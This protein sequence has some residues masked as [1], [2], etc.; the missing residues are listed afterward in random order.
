MSMAEGQPMRP[1]RAPSFSSKEKPAIAA[2]P[3]P[4][5]TTALPPPPDSSTSPAAQHEDLQPAPVNPSSKSM[6][7]SEDLS[8]SESMATP[9]NT[10]KPTSDNTNQS[11]PSKQRSPPPPRP[12]PAKQQSTEVA[13]QSACDGDSTSVTARPKAQSTSGKKPPPPRPA[14]AAPEPTQASAIHQHP[15][16]PAKPAP[17][18]PSPAQTSTNANPA[19]ADAPE[20]TEPSHGHAP[21]PAKAAPKLKD[22]PS[23]EH[24]APTDATRSTDE[25]PPADA[26][27]TP[28]SSGHAP[29]PARPPHPQ[30]SGSIK[31][32]RPPPARPAHPAPTPK[33]IH[34]QPQSKDKASVRTSS[35]KT[36]AKAPL[37]PSPAAAPPKPAAPARPAAPAQPPEL[38]PRPGPGHVLY[39]YMVTGPRVIEDLPGNRIYEGWP[40]GWQAEA[41]LV[42]DPK[43]E[44][45]AEEVMAQAFEDAYGADVALNNTEPDEEGEINSSANAQAELLRKGLPEDGADLPVDESGPTPDVV[46]IASKGDTGSSSLGSTEVEPFLHPHSIEAGPP[47]V[48]AL[49]DFVAEGPDDLAFFAGQELTVLEDID[50]EWYRGSL[51]PFQGIFPKA[52][53]QPLDSSTPSEGL[54]QTSV[55]PEP[56][57]SLEVVKPEI[58]NA[59]PEE[60]TASPA[61]AAEADATPGLETDASADHGDAGAGGSYPCEAKVLYDYDSPELEDLSV[62]AGETITVLERIN[63]EWL[64]AAKRSGLQGQLPAAFV[65]MESQMRSDADQDGVSTSGPEGAGVGLRLVVLYDFS[66]ENEDD[67]GAMAGD[68]VDVIEVVNE[69]WL[70]AR[71]HAEGREGLIPRA[72][73]E[74]FA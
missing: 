60:S 5:A 45:E 56:S 16:P 35:V 62:E 57:A 13:L 3:K 29:A 7:A 41:T 27:T 28:P 42:R 1:T 14:A 39:S 4:K 70:R 19:A 37:R 26:S 66:A 59:A 20:P 30:R 48:V 67:L 12:A 22:A 15:P 55:M 73:V 36:K 31:P 54:S 52:F 43:A 10:K 72:N 53:V 18:A 17:H 44:L 71:H 11:T 25:T 47:V 58:A 51:G 38:P 8:Q 24:P 32:L 21:P 68:E 34:A 64:L 49:Y 63:A 61:G 69:D 6:P 40:E 33:S 50:H 74:S 2:K 23:D 65:E 9:D 46:Q